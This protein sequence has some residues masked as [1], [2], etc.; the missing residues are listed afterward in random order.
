M[1]LEG[2][3]EMK[4]P[5]KNPCILRPF[6]AL[7]PHLCQYYCQHWFWLGLGY[8]RW[9]ASVVTG[10]HYYQCQECHDKKPEA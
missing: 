10:T 3:K 2:T 8:R 9:E 7:V 1:L 4:W 5:Y 6:F